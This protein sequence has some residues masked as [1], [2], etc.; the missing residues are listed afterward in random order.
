MKKK[1]IYEDNILEEKRN[2]R[3]EIKKSSNNLESEIKIKED[4]IN[5][6]NLLKKNKKN[7]L[8][9]I[10]FLSENT[11][12]NKYKDNLFT[13]KKINSEKILEKEEKNILKYNI[14]NLKSIIYFENYKLIT[15]KKYLHLSL[16]KENYLLSVNE[17]KLFIEGIKIIDF[18]NSKFD[19]DDFNQDIIIESRINNCFVYWKI[20]EILKGKLNPEKILFV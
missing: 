6:E 18:S 9:K 8:K 4:T 12:S 2:Y 10:N 14:E 7:S 3:N 15:Y 17:K 1:G 19:K 13:K 20:S 5:L 16:K 11:N